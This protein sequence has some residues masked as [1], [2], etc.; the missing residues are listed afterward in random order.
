V[1]ILWRKLQTLVKVLKEDTHYVLRPQCLIL[2]RPPF[3]PVRP[4]HYHH[5]VEEYSFVYCIWKGDCSVAYL[6][7]RGRREV[8]SKLGTEA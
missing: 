2:K 4:W 7:A 5:N 1:I 6:G 8:F 3:S